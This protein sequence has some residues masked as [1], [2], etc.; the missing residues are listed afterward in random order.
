MRCARAGTFR[1]RRGPSAPRLLLDLRDLRPEEAV[2]ELFELLRIAA[3][4]EPVLGRQVARPEHLPPRQ[5]AEDVDGALLVALDEY[6]VAAH[7]VLDDAPQQW[8]MRAA[9][10]QRIDF[11]FDQRRQVLLC[12]ALHLG[13]CRLAALDQFYEKR[14]GVWIELD[15]L[16]RH[17]DRAHVR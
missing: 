6:H 9:Q 13:A 14:T 8:V 4:N 2:T 10:D 12:D 7:H 3:R 5:F 17:S 1:R 11:A 15:V 16:A